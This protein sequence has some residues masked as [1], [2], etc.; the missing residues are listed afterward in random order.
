MKPVAV[1][2]HVEFLWSEI[3]TK[4]KDIEMKIYM[5]TFVTG[6]VNFINNAFQYPLQK[7][8]EIPAAVLVMGVNMPDHSHIFNLLEEHLH[9]N[10]IY[11]SVILESKKCSSV[12]N[13]LQVILFEIHK[14][15]TEF[16]KLS[17]DL[18]KK[19][20]YGFAKLYEYY[21]SIQVASP[22]KKAKTIQNKTQHSLKPIVFLIQDVESF[23]PEILQKLIYLCKLS[24]PPITFQ[25]WPKEFRLIV[26]RIYH[27]FSSL[28]DYMLKIREL[29]SV[30]LEKE[31][32]LDE[33]YTQSMNLIRL[34]SKENLMAKLETCLNIICDSY[35]ENGINLKSVNSIKHIVEDCIERLSKISSDDFEKNLPEPLIFQNEKITSRFQLQ[36]KIQMNLKLKR[37]NFEV[38]LSGIVQNLNMI[39]KNI[40]PP[41]H[42]PLYEIFY[43]DDVSA[44]KKHLM[45]VPRV[46]SC[47]TLSNPH[48]Y[49]QC[50]CCEITSPDEVR[51]TMP[52]ISILYKL[53]LQSGKLINLYDWLEPCIGHL[54]P[55]Y[56]LCLDEY[57]YE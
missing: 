32:S 5:E 56:G 26:V 35:E 19:Q 52:E 38:V 29:Y 40:S 44:A 43:F 12:Q 8:Q 15:Y 24:F 23:N 21:C 51:P 2:E 28:I 3:E 25:I 4:I 31:I 48:Y 34:H 47:C 46:T 36:E 16:F 54:T 11:S 13:M 10:D 18:P 14:R 7:V 17:E 30:S 57:E 45:A 6:I 42:S 20:E 41:S 33:G 39:F 27:D 9:L 37:S 49:L 1:K 55:A 22:K 50:K 53:H